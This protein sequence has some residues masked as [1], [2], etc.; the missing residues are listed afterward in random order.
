MKQE[1]T[2]KRTMHRTDI[3]VDITAVNMSPDCSRLCVGTTCSVQRNGHSENE[4]E[5][6]L[7]SLELSHNET[8]LQ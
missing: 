5:S 3:A 4:T 2:S 8:H 1:M 7:C 6:M